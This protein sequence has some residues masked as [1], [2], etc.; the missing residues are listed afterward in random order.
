MKSRNSFSINLDKVKVAF[1][2]FMPL[3]LSP[4]L[5]DNRGRTSLSFFEGSY[6]S[7][8]KEYFS[9]LKDNYFNI[10]DITTIPGFFQDSLDESLQKR[11][12]L[13]C[14]VDAVVNIDCDIYKPALLV[15]N[16]VAPMLRQGSVV[17]FDDWYSYALAPNKG[18]VPALNEFLHEN[19]RFLVSFMKR[20]RAC[21]PIIYCW[22]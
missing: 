22:P 6:S 13:K 2:V 16:F 14:P 5:E 4:A 11:I 10:G 15:L 1:R 19:S 18:E 9:F 7:T 12:V 21:G 20:L 17:L 3:I 8:T